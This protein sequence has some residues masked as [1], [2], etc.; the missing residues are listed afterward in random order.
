MSQLEDAQEVY[1]VVISGMP[2]FSPPY[3]LVI[4]LSQ[5]M[6]DLYSP[7]LRWEVVFVHCSAARV[8]WKKQSWSLLLEGR[9]PIARK[10]SE[11]YLC[12]L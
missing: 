1:L 8:V 9:L 7:W 4:P 12:L 11:G 3:S 2:S 10:E 6:V 5:R